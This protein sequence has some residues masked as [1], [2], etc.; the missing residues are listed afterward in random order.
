MIEIARLGRAELTALEEAGREVADW[1]RILAKTGDTILGRVLDAAAEPEDWLHYPTGDVYDPA[2]HAQYFYHRHEAGSRDRDQSREYGHFHTFM[3]P[4]GMAP[5]TQP[6]VM[7]E[8]AIAEV[9]APPLDPMLP[10]APQPNQG[11]GNERFSHLIAVAVDRNALPV[12]L[13]TTNRWVTGETW[14]A[15]DDVIAMIDRF[16]IEVARPSWPLNR[17]LSALVRLYRP[18]I[19]TLL[20]ERDEA[21]MAWRRRHRKVHVFEDRRLETI[22]SLAVDPADRLR[23]IARALGR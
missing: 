16:S 21:V 3:R 6:L 2:T 23:R 17:W 12:R 7:P 1:P 11:E 20:R 8:F 5:G 18:E 13:F 9:P 10:P 14:Y 4:R 15:G 22:S 19:A